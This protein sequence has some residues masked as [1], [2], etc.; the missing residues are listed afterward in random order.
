MFLLEFSN[1]RSQPVSVT[2]GIISI[3]VQLLQSFRRFLEGCLVP[4]CLLLSAI[5]E[6]L[7]EARRQRGA[8]C[9][10]LMQ[11]ALSLLERSRQLAD[12]AGLRC[13]SL[14]VS[15]PLLLDLPA[16]LRAELCLSGRKEAAKRLGLTRRRRPP[17]FRLLAVAGRGSE[18]ISQARHFVLQIGVRGFRPNYRRFLIGDEAAM[19]NPADTEIRNRNSSR[20]NYQEG[21]RLNSW[22]QNELRR[23]SRCPIDNLYFG[24]K[25][26]SPTRCF[27]DHAPVPRTAEPWMSGGKARTRLRLPLVEGARSGFSDK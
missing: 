7:A 4:V 3:G 1:S 13:G 20:D 26:A 19:A 8:L 11:L 2:R 17:R 5:G 16:L 27:G 25:R 24:E 9:L 23:P 6:G 10:D 12:S 22:R 21:C 15:R 14:F 18:L